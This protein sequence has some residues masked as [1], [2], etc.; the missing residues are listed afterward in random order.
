M[1]FPTGAPMT[2]PTD[3]PAQSIAHAAERAARTVTA[4]HPGRALMEVQIELVQHLGRS[5]GHALAEHE[6][7]ALAG[8]FFSLT[9][10]MLD[11]DVEGPADR[12]TRGLCSEEVAAL[13][14]SLGANALTTFARMARID[15]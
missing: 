3:D 13:T 15:A 10:P 9:A 11:I 14:T 12:A 5:F 7:A 1:T 6:A 2:F 4:A 8:F